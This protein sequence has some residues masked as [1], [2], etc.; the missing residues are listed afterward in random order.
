MT[1]LKAVILF[2]LLCHVPSLTIVFELQACTEQII[3]GCMAFYFSLC[4]AHIT[5]L[6]IQTQS[7]SQYTLTTYSFN[8]S[9]LPIFFTYITVHSLAAYKFNSYCNPNSLTI[10]TRFQMTQYLNITAVPTKYLLLKF[11]LVAWCLT[12]LS[13]QKGY[14]VPCEK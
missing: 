1:A 3:D 12:A 7:V 5:K 8:R 2:A 6:Q 9:L 14:I 11:M 13:A 4:Q 10:I